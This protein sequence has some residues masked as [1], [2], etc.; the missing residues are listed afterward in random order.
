MSAQ[1]AIFWVPAHLWM[2]EYRIK[3]QSKK[4]MF[5]AGQS[6]EKLGIATWLA[7]LAGLLSKWVNFP[8]SPNVVIQPFSIQAGI[9][10]KTAELDTDF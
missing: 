10:A 4:F 1:G 2:I 9:I 7:G 8:T 6:E 3:A 5:L